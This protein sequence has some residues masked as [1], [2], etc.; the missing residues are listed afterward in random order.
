MNSKLD[1]QK[2]PVNYV[3][4]IGWALEGIGENKA[5]LFSELGI[6]VGDLEK[7]EGTI[8]GTQY[9]NLIEKGISLNDSAIPF[10]FLIAKHIKVTSHGILG[11]AAMSANNLGEILELSKFFPLLMPGVEF[12]YFI[13]NGEVTCEFTPIEELGREASASIVEIY[14]L[15]F[16]QFSFYLEAPMSERRV[17]FSHETSYDKAVY[18]EYFGCHVEFGCSI[19][20]VVIPERYLNTALIFSDPSTLNLSKR[21]LEKGLKQLSIKNQ[22]SE[23]VAN[24]WRE[25]ALESKYLIQDE[26]ATDFNMTVRTL[27]RK[28]NSENT[29]YQEVVGIVR[30]NMAV[31]YLVETNMRIFE[32]A[33]ATG[34]KDTSTFNRAF[35]SWFKCTPS[36][37]RSKH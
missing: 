15:T 10:S 6:S 5:R 31:T 26:L 22:W 37:Y 13:H 18:D 11:L 28:L 34:F 7:P 1:A 19:N 33:L 16:L 35:K 4:A 20:K 12:N 8:R 24:Y 36:A 14:A 25:C 27:A 17:C 3:S 32:I 9:K 29:N 2:I 23:K 21:F 30:K